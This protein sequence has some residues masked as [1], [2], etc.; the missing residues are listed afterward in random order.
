LKKVFLSLGS[1]KGNR[2]VNLTNALLKINSLESTFISK[3]SSYY[4]T[5]PYGVEN[6]SKFLNLVAEIQTELEPFLLHQKLVE[7]ENLLG[8]KSKGDL[9]PREIDIDILFYDDLAIENEFLI[10]PHRDLH[11]RRFVLEPL[12]EI[13]PDFVHPVFKKNIKQLLSQL[14]DNLS[15]TKLI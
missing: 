6:Q 11:N 12:A 9:K 7:I 5:E 8:R 15:V 4:E 10:I 1:N 2:F 14:K 3:I 13:N